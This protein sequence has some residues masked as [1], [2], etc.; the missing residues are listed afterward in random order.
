MLSDPAERVF[1]CYS[2]SPRY[3]RGGGARLLRREVTVGEICLD[4]LLQE[5]EKTLYAEVKCCTLVAGCAYLPEAL[6]QRMEQ[7][8]CFYPKS[9]QQVQAVSPLK[10]SVCFGYDASIHKKDSKFKLKPPGY[11]GRLTKEPLRRLLPVSEALSSFFVQIPVGDFP[12]S[13]FRRDFS[14]LSS[15]PVEGGRI[16]AA[17]S[18]LFFDEISDDLTADF[19]EQD[20][21]QCQ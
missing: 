20:H 16:T 5:N 3:S 15:C 6:S 7:D 10:C 12:F 9:L 13:P 4:F 21:G 17:A 19:V 1:I 11:G 18:L 14:V 2:R 8:F